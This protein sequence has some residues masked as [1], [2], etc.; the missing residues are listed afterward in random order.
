MKPPS[1]YSIVFAVT[2]V[3]FAS[4]GA[5]IQAA[6]MGVFVVICWNNGD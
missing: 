5:W 2:V 4:F 6:L 1:K 3:G